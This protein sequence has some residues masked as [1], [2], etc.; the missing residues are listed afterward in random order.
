MFTLISKPSMWLVA[1]LPVCFIATN[2]ALAIDSETETVNCYEPDASV[3]SEID[4]VKVG[5]DTT[6]FIVGFCDERVTITKDGITLSGNKNGW[7]TKGGGLTGVTVIGAQRVKI[8]YLNLTGAGYGVLAQEGAA[9]TISNNNISYNEEYGIG[10]WYQ[11]FARVELNTISH[12]GEYG[13]S[14]FQNANVASTGNTITDNAVAAI[15]IGNFSVYK[16][17]RGSDDAVGDII[18]Q[19]GCSKGQTAVECAG[20][21]NIAE[22]LIDC[23]RNCLIDMRNSDTTGFISFSNG[24][25][26]V[27]ESTINGN[28]DAGGLSSINFLT[29]GIGVTGSGVLT[30]FGSDVNTNNTLKCFESIPAP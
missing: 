23:Y 18:V 16:T 9:V 28:I 21:M 5:R 25:F 13:L 20:S 12:N 26:T 14:I 6:I 24:H 7:D 29:K 2:T 11:A 8:E 17:G 30:C 15:D 1:V 19:G 3:Q 22:A 10:V 27:R 4:D